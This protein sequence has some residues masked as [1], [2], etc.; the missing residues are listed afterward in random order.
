MLEL[1]LSLM[2]WI[3]F[4]S[5]LVFSCCRLIFFMAASNDIKNHQLGQSV[6]QD[7]NQHGVC[8]F[9]MTQLSCAKLPCD[10]TSEQLGADVPTACFSTHSGASYRTHGHWGFALSAW[11]KWSLSCQHQNSNNTLHWHSSQMASV[12]DHYC[13][14]HTFCKHK[15]ILLL[16]TYIK[17][18]SSTSAFLGGFRSC[19]YSWLHNKTNIYIYYG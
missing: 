18:G 11:Q 9:G 17:T 5:S 10:W 7:S 15:I 19:W 3:S 1:F 14:S 8:N 13:H 2:I 6:G 16:G 12:Y 4:S